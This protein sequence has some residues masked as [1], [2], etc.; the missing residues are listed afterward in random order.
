M[1]VGKKKKKKKKWGIFKRINKWRSFGISDILVNL[2]IC[3]HIPNLLTK[4]HFRSL[5]NDKLKSINKLA[6]I[7]RGNF[8]LVTSML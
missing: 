1:K 4:L 2:S 8:H 6:N 5:A 7:N 3:L